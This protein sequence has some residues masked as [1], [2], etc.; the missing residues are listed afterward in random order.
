MVINV[1]PIDKVIRNCS[2]K[3]FLNANSSSVANDFVID[4]PSYLKLKVSLVVFI[5]VRVIANEKVKN[6]NLLEKSF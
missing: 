1:E 3:G 6:L 4:E 2:Q 5:I